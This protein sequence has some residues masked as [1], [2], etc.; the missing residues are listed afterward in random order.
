LIG[1]GEALVIFDNHSDS[2]I[3]KSLLTVNR[4]D[5]Y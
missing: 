4:Y 3:E 5:I 1:V 2:D